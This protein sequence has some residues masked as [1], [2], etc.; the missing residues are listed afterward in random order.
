MAKTYKEL[1]DTMRELR[2]D[3]TIWYELE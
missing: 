3:T 1:A 2:V